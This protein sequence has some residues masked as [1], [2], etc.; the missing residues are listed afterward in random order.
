M[1]RLIW[2]Y[3]RFKLGNS[4]ITY[5]YDRQNL[6]IICILSYFDIFPFFRELLPLQH[7]CCYFNQPTSYRCTLHVVYSL[8]SAIHFLFA[9]PV[10]PRLFTVVVWLYRILCQ[11]YGRTL[12]LC[13]QHTQR[14]VHYIDI[15][16]TA[17]WFLA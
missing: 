8:L 12:R 13:D 1:I 7:V 10:K 6:N 11:K 17:V 5:I 3:V 4:T 15:H 14:L 2:S 9:R 16:T